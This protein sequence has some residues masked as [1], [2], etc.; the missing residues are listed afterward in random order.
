MTCMAPSWRQPKTCAPFLFLIKPGL[1]FSLGFHPCKH[2][3][4]KLS[5]NAHLLQ[6]QRKSICFQRHA[7]QR[8]AC[9]E[10]RLTLG[11]VNIRRPFCD[12]REKSH[13]PAVVIAV[14]KPIDKLFEPFSHTCM[15]Y[16]YVE[17]IFSHHVLSGKVLFYRMSQ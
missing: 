13:C 17:D 15:A 5:D 11:E 7:G 2:K 12:R 8:Y 6:V 1:L 9:N 4:L 3:P 16:P 10:K 14:F